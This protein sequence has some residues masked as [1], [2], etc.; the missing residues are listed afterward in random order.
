M[1]LKNS[2]FSYREG[3]E[4]ILDG[5]EGAKYRSKAFFEASNY[6][7]VL[8]K[9]VKFQKKGTVRLVNQKSKGSLRILE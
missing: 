3:A 2:Q 4:Q 7:F 1:T 5:F 6:D 8:I 9:N